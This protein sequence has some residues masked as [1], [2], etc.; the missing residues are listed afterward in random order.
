MDKKEMAMRL[1]NLIQIN[2]MLD[3]EIKKTT[4]G[5]PSFCDMD[6]YKESKAILQKAAIGILR[7][8][9]NE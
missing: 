3:M 9:D 6:D 7:K 2:D 8:A 1:L 4:D 5:A